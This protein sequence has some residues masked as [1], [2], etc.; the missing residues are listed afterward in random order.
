MKRFFSFIIRQSVAV[1]LIV[2]FLLGFGIF[3]TVNMAI[4]LLPDINVPVVCIQNIYVGASASSVEK[5]VTALVEEGVSS[6]SGV[7]NVVS[8][9]YDNLSAV[10]LMFDYGTDTD[11]KKSE[12]SSKLS[13]IS[14]PDGV[15]TTIYDL[16]L[17]AEA[18]AVL[19]LT[20]DK[21]ETEQ[22]NLKNAYTAANALSAKLA[23]IDGVES[24]EIKGAPA[25]NIVIKPFGGLELCTPLFVQAFSYGALSLPL[26]NLI[27]N[28]GSVQIRNNTDVTSL[29]D[30]ENTPVTLP[31]SIV[32][33]FTKV[34]DNIRE[35]V[36]EYGLGD[37]YLP[38]VAA[39]VAENQFIINIIK[40][41]LDQNEQAKDL[42]ISEDLVK[43]IILSD[44]SEVNSEG[45]LTV[46]VKDVAKIDREDSFSSY[47]YFAGGEAKLVHGTVIEIYKSNGANAAAV[48]DKV[49]SIYADYLSDGA[50]EEYGAK[51]TLLDD[52]SQFI[53]DSVSN[54]LVSMLI[55]GVLAVAV[56]FLFL[57]KA[58]TSVIIAITMPLSVLAALI[59]LYIMGITLNMVS[60][61]GLAVGIG[62]LV[63]NSIVVIE[64]ISKHRETGKSAFDA[65][66][67][68]TTEVGGALLGS[69]LTTVCVFIPII[70]SGG[71]TGEIFTE[72]SFAVIFSLTFSLIIAL[73]V[74]PSLY[75]MFHS[76][77]RMLK[78]GAKVQRIEK[79][80]EEQAVKESVIQ[81]TVFEPAEEEKKQK[82]EKKFAVM[83][84]ITSFYGRI[85]PKVLCHK[86]ITIVVAIVLFAGSVGLLFVTGTEFLPSIDK[87]QIEIDITFEENLSIAE[88]ETDVYKFADKL[89]NTMDNVEYI[90]V[91]VGKNGMLALK[92]TGVITVQL[93]TNRGT[94]KVVDEIRTVAKA[95][96]ESKELRGTANVREIDGVVA[97][98][99]SGTDD[100]SVTITGDDYDKLTEISDEI[101]V[102]LRENGFEDVTPSALASA[103]EFDL[104]FNRYRMEKLGIDYQTLVLTLR[105]GIASYTACSVTI[106]GQNYNLNVRFADG[107]V[108]TVDDLRNL[109]VGSDG[110]QTVK[111]SEICE[112]TELT[113]EACIRRSNGR[114]MVA[115]SAAL[116]GVDMGSASSKM[117]KI[118]AEVVNRYEGYEFVSSGVSSYLT[119]AFEGLAVA[120]VVSFFLLFAV[121]AI[122]FG[123]ALK[124]L[125]IMASIPFSF[126]GGF[127]ALVITGTTLNV[128][129]FIGLIML[130]G[131]VVNN[132][133]VMLEKIKQLCD[134]GMEHY[135]AVCE[136]CK[137]RLR[138]ILMTT[139]TTILALIPM[140]IGV[141]KGSELMQ[142]L[143]IVVMGGLLLG[144]LVTLILV[145]AVYCAVHRLGNKKK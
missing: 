87:G 39:S 132:A 46:K 88:A 134:E 86:L 124:P 135:D 29:E 17:N 83:N 49:K 40:Q 119:D 23:A 60:L 45:G 92:D 93:K 48:V 101:C 121:M 12:I 108:E 73:S 74:I 113:A 110:G 128:V 120:L 10:A 4:N 89:W 109:V 21:S 81:D 33:I 142:P 90:S 41:M 130:M 9:S 85:L 3:S 94:E 16:D 54:V 75:V 15:E 20:S 7:T 133:I 103:K 137:V 55:G 106:D 25:E 58:K 117:Q 31:K 13:G 80:K 67:D 123:S 11:E 62:M 99:T 95:S 19:S 98:L 136:A 27:Q 139:L 107:A 64:S 102:K 65:A 141:G 51:I 36:L 30:I 35:G 138:P 61:G 42:H 66:V 32:E 57:R 97:S 8:Y 129:S 140:A 143:G 76:G 126:T 5:D 52:Q 96:K 84:A 122:Q 2:I 59:C 116:P 14:L 68:G 125:I 77:K 71:L 100:M 145:P 18:L 50:S 127:V 37:I 131:V 43:Y 56:I 34:K 111:L 26:G 104:K 115:V 112:I 63:D 38:E 47:V 6:I 44:L 1:V 28:G 70:F 82:P 53:S 105:I 24:V 69:T 91:D 118:A 114:R 79:P 72:L 78:E 144:T 22:E